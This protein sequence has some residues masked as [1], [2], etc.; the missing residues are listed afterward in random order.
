MRVED[1]VIS[2]ANEVNLIVESDVLNQPGRIRTAI[3][4]VLMNAIGGG[5]MITDEDLE[6]KEGKGYELG[7]CLGVGRVSTILRADAGSAFATGDDSG[8]N[9]LRSLATRFDKEET[10]LR[11]AYDKKYPKG[12]GNE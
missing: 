5:D 2:I 12:D 9:M 11:D 8:A 1:L 3:G 10:Q 6:H 7:I 4:H